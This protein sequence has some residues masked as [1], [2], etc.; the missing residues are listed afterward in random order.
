MKY[1]YDKNLLSHSF[2]VFVPLPVIEKETRHVLCNKPSSTLDVFKFF[3]ILYALSTYII[4]MAVAVLTMSHRRP[5][6]YI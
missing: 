2:T 4:D 6:V 1:V 3:I 5:Y